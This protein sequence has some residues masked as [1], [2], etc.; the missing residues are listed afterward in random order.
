MLEPG[1]GP[2]KFLDSLSER[3]LLLVLW[4][5]F[6]EFKKS[7]ADIKN[8][9]RDDRLASEQQFQLMER[10]IRALEDKAREA[11]GM[12]AGGRVLLWLVARVSAIAGYFINERGGP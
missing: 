6:Q 8:E 4:T 9:L 7:Q 1:L 11:V 5:E 2:Q 10:R 12:F 3:D